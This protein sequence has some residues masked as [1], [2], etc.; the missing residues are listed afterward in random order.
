MS[1]H[2]IDMAVTNF[3]TISQV[4][5]V[6]VTKVTMVQVTET[7]GT[8]L[9]ALDVLRTPSLTGETAVAVSDPRDPRTRARAQAH[10]DAHAST[11]TRA[12]ARAR[13]DQCARCG[14]RW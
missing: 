10:A 2:D 5:E 13:A 3:P 4:R 11:C 14:W 6:K 8:T 7:R 1:V 12:Q 9:F